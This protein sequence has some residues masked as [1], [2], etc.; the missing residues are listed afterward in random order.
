MTNDFLWGV[1]SSG[2]QCEG[3]YNGPGQPQNNWAESETQDRVM[4]TGQ[5]AD[6][7]HRYEQDFAR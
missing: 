7:W 5:A 1:A 3:G 2:Y 4:R 6:F